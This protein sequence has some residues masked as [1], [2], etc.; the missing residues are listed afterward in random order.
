MIENVIYEMIIMHYII[1]KS[2]IYDKF[3]YQ[4]KKSYLW[5]YIYIF[6]FYLKDFLGKSPRS[7]KIFF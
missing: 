4:T 6:L 7:K 5:K 3:I 2:V 1:V